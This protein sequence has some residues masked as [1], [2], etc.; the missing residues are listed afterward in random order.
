MYIYG[1]LKNKIIENIFKTVKN[2]I[3]T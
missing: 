2:Y 1:K 3:K